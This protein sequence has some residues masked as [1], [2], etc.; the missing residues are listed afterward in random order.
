MG[1]VVNFCENDRNQELEKLGDCSPAKH[2]KK[3]NEEME[4]APDDKH[5][6]AAEAEERTQV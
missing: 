1:D 2:K 5:E 4:D 6:D 3:S